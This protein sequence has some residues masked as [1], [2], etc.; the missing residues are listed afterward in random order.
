MR[1][2]FR[3]VLRNGDGNALIE[4][5]IALPVLILIMSGVV[6]FGY[7]FAVSNN[8]QTV[9]S[10]TARLLAIKRI[11]PAEAPAYAQS[12]LMKVTGTYQVNANVTSTDVT[13]AITLPRSN[14][15]LINVT[16]LLSSGDL[17]AAST[18]RVIS[19]EG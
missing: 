7:M 2:P 12:R 13:V 19:N 16:G 14:A 1:I 9:S 18:M 15:V 3:N 10:E 4:T 17:S 8:M 5:A 11:T 6:D